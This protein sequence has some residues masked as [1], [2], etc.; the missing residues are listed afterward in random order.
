VGL[1]LIKESHKISTSEYGFWL[2]GGGMAG[3]TAGVMLAIP[4]AFFGIILTGIGLFCILPPLSYGDGIV[5]PLGA[6]I[7][8]TCFGII[9][10]LPGVLLLRREIQDRKST[11]NGGSKL[12]ASQKQQCLGKPTQ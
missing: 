1:Y 7:I 2:V 8:K 12:P 10:F 3:L 5:A 4:R 6:H 11:A 9:L